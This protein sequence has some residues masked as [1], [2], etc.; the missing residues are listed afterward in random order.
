MTFVRNVSECF[1]E[2]LR[3]GRDL[4]IRGNYKFDRQRLATLHRFVENNIWKKKK[5]KKIMFF[6]CTNRAVGSG[7]MARGEE[8][9][10]G[11]TFLV[12]FNICTRFIV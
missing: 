11:S 8:P 9:V 3:I 2:Y 6:I 12:M 7:L 10:L 4:P 5:N 1:F